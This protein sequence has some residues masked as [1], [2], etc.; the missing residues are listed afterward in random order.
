LSTNLRFSWTDRYFTNDFNGPK[1][2]EVGDINN[3][4]ND[5]Y[6]LTNLV[7]I[8]RL[9]VERFKFSI[10]LGVENILDTRYNDSIV[11]NAFGNYFFE[12]ASGRAWYFS[13]TL[14]I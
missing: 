12:P 3:Y 13:T 11:P 14:E 8:Y 4:I 6:F 7:L 5:S 9:N 2:N 1:P 10:K